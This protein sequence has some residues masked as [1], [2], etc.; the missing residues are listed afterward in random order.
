MTP[1]MTSFQQ[2]LEAKKDEL[3]FEEKYLS[4]SVDLYDLE[5]SQRELDNKTTTN[6][7]FRLK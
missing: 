6:F 3:S 5:C 1:I 4:K 2:V 7:N